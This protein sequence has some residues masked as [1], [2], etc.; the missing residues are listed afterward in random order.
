MSQEKN[1]LNKSNG[2]KKIECGSSLSSRAVASKVLSAQLSL[3]SVFGMGTGGSSTLSP[4]QWL[5]NSYL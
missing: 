3:T 2:F 4:P 5:Y 1:R